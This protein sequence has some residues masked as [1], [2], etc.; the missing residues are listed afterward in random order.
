MGKTNENF[1]GKHAENIHTFSE[2]EENDN[3]KHSL[4]FSHLSSC[5]ATGGNTKLNSDSIKW[6]ATFDIRRTLSETFLIVV[7]C[8]ES[9]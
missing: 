3:S 6:R 2:K 5:L 1:P 4:S 7:F 8:I 9:K